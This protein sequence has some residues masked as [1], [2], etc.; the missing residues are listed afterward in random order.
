M[1]LTPE[2]RARFEAGNCI[3]C[4]KRTD[5]RYGKPALECKPCH[6]ERKG[7]VGGARSQERFS[8]Y[9]GSLNMAREFRARTGYSNGAAGCKQGGDGD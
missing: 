2:Q 6:L 8:R 4:G 1:P 5:I 7:P 3:V 9:S